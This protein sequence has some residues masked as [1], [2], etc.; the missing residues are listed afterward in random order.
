MATCRSINCARDTRRHRINTPPP[1]S[2]RIACKGA[3]IYVMRFQS[4]AVCFSLALTVLLWTSV[5]C[6]Q[7]PVKSYSPLLQT[8]QELSLNTETA[9]SPKMSSIWLGLKD[10]LLSYICQ[11]YG[12]VRF[13]ASDRQNIGKVLK[14]LTTLS[15]L[16]EHLKYVGTIEVDEVLA[17]YLLLSELSLVKKRYPDKLERKLMKWPLPKGNLTLSLLISNAP[18]R[19]ST[20]ESLASYLPYISDKPAR[21]AAVNY[22]LDACA[23][24]STNLE[25]VHFLIL[26]CAFEHRVVRKFK[27]ILRPSEESNAFIASGLLHFAPAELDGTLVEDL[28]KALAVVA[29]TEMFT[30][31]WTNFISYPT[32]HRDLDSMRVIFERN[33]QA[34]QANTLFTAEQRTALSVLN[35]IKFGA[36]QE[37]EAMSEA[38]RKALFNMFRGKDKCALVFHI[39]AREDVEKD[40]AWAQFA[41]DRSNTSILSRLAF[42]LE[43]FFQN[44]FYLD[45]ANGNRSDFSDFLDEFKYYPSSSKKQRF[46]ELL[47]AKIQERSQTMLVLFRSCLSLEHLGIFFIDQGDK[48][49]LMALNDFVFQAI[50]GPLSG[51]LRNLVDHWGIVPVCQLLGGRIGGGFIDDPLRLLAE[52]VGAAK[53][54]RELNFSSLPANDV[55][56]LLTTLGIAPEQMHAALYSIN[57]TAA[58]EDKLAAAMQRFHDCGQDQN[59]PHTLPEYH[60]LW[61]YLWKEHREAFVKHVHPKIQRHYLP[62]EPSSPTNGKDY[63]PIHLA[64]KKGNLNRLNKLID[65]GADI[66]I[67]NNEGRAPIH[68][69]CRKGHLGILNRLIGAGAKIDIVDS[70]GWAPIHLACFYGHLEIVNRL[71]EAGAEINIV[72][73]DRWAPIHTACRKGHL[74]ILNRLIGA[75]AEINVLTKTGHAPIHIVCMMGRIRMLNRLIEAG[76]QVNIGD[77]RERAPINIACEE[78]QLGILNR[79]TEARADICIGDMRGLNPIHLA[80]ELGY[81]EILNILIGAGADIQVKNNIGRAPIHIACSKGNLAILH[82]LIEAGASIHDK[83]DTGQSPIDIV[84]GNSKLYEVLMPSEARPPRPSCCSIS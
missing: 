29:N 47:L 54:L 49:G 5:V 62:K 23:K 25:D 53:V 13:N 18:I 24:G 84:Q 77:M 4:I 67:M 33:A 48:V 57:H 80:C 40:G 41:N 71:I 36:S 1:G 35:K 32:T 56:E 6:A 26:R 75:G 39:W 81:L 28:N 38:E 34:F 11:L 59:R 74:G 2:S 7:G 20:L 78:S 79:L 76:A 9:P 16:F 15:R 60:G 58:P 55:G 68:T 63:K 64:S 37:I 21:L 22:C 73:N 42:R 72:S 66:N 14:V 61:F 65:A 83:D 50:R 45:L 19:E 46:H 43:W 30:K 52:R 27:R 8:T 44:H 12:P 69:A 10:D 51:N 31:F 3:A 70:D 17:Y 82:R